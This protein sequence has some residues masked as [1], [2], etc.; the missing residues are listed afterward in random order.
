MELNMEYTTKQITEDRRK[1]EQALES[2]DYKKGKKYLRTENNEYC[3]LGVAC[4]LFDNNA[5]LIYGRYRYGSRGAVATARVVNALGLYSQNGRHEDSHT[6][7]AQ[8]NDISDSFEP[9]ISA[10][11][12][13]NYY[14]ELDKQ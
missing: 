1:W 11:K 10:I 8:I 9:V 6:T 4:E 12:T 13:G 3:C 2:G 5:K 14:K 7:L